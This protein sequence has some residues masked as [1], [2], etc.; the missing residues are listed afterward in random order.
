ML[1]CPVDKWTVYNTRIQ[2]DER[3]H[4]TVTAYVGEI[5]C[6]SVFSNPVLN[7]KYRLKPMNKEDGDITVQL[8]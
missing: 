4:S 1:C 8:K 2:R 3:L 5:E 6:D 7:S